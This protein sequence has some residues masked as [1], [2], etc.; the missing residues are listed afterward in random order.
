MS[1][2]MFLG[3]FFL[4]LFAGAELMLNIFKKGINQALDEAEKENP[5]G[6]LGIFI[7]STIIF[8]IILKLFNSYVYTPQSQFEF[9]VEGFVYLLALLYVGRR[10]FWS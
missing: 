5:L 7:L 6:D 8:G 9:A 4:L 3:F 2:L 1:G 10:V